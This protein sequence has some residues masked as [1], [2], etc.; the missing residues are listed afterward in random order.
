M[1]YGSKVLQHRIE[2]E[3]RIRKWQRVYD[4]IVE[5]KHDILH[6]TLDGHKRCCIN[7]CSV[8]ILTK[9]LLHKGSLELMFDDAQRSSFIAVPAN[10]YRNL[11]WISVHGI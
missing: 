4:F 2:F 7:N 3:L 8:K 6:L 5:R 9:S 10:L 11:I 1:K